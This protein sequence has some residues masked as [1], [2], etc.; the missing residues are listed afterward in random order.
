MHAL[1]VL[2]A[3]PRSTSARSA[4]DRS[5]VVAFPSRSTVTASRRTGATRTS[6]ADGFAEFYRDNLTAMTR[7]A[8]LLVG[9]REAAQ[10][11]T[12]DAFVRVHAKWASV[13]EPKAYLRRAVVNACNSHHRRRGVERRLTPRPADTDVAASAPDELFDALAQLPY[14]QRAVLVLRYYHDMSEAEIAATLGV[15]PGTVGSLASRG[16]ER[17]RAVIEP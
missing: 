16:L 3:V 10:D 5:N 17:L 2:A 8:F 14:R 13:T 12:Q 4:P 6:G 11:L 7:L 1:P 9:S 15:R